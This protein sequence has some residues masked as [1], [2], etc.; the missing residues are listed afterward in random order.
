[1]LRALLLTALALASACGGE[2]SKPDRGAPARRI[3]SLSPA[4]SSAIL[5]MGWGDRLV[6]RTPWCS[7]SD[8][9]PVVGSL[10]EVDLER[11]AAAKPELI[12]MQR[13]ASGAPAGLVEAA[14]ARGWRVVSVPCTTLDDVQALGSA[15]EAAVGESAP[16]DIGPAAWREVQAPLAGA[17]RASPAIL[18]LS[19]D[20]PMAF[21]RDA[22]LS[23]LWRR[24]GGVTLPDSP[25]HPAL[26]LE[27]L[28]ALRPRTIVLAGA[29]SA[30][31][32]LAQACAARGIALMVVEDPRLL[33]PGPDLLEAAHAW[34]RQ[35]EQGAP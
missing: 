26:S 25:G 14:A 34:R 19:S 21:G 12:L 7:G 33:R 27:D 23:E 24:W 2:P 4:I 29:P 3:A 18:L 35:L 16:R 9:T 20:P 15:I 30:S 5:A 28:T 22:Y 13:A 10:L 31:A 6:G 8:A 32:G 17:Q 11:L 1:M